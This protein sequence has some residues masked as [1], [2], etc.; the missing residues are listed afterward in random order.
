MKNQSL[1]SLAGKT[2]LVTGGTGVLGGAMALALAQAGA[3]VAV[4]GRNERKLQEM[5]HKIEQEG[6]E[7]LTLAADVTRTKQLEEASKK[8][9]D[10]FK[11]LDI[12][13]NAAGGNISGATITPDQSILD[14]SEEDLRKIVELNYLGTVLPIQV[15]SQSMIEKKEG[16]IINISSM[17]A[18]RPLTRVM[19]YASSKAA[20]DNYTQWLAVELAQKYGEGLRVN[21][22]APG[23][24]LTEQNKSLLTEEDGSLT[25]RGKQIVSH[26]PFGR[27][28]KPE[29]LNGTL[30]WLCSD[31]SRFVTGT[32]IPV[33]G[34]FNAYSGV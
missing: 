20:I 7:A 13:V 11:K 21:A 17:A 28:G 14:L 27:F 25:A 19:G 33:D 16:N 10:K 29:D 32:I 26:T 4:L 1:F 23:F 8:L 9:L 30:L 2:A 34:G 22:I 24:F 5:V 15:F 6:V 31:A 3:H 12:L 18:Q